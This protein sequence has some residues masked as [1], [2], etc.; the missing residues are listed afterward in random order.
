MNL[1][2]KSAKGEAF[3]EQAVIVSRFFKPPSKRSDYEM[4]G[5]EKLYDRNTLNMDMA[6]I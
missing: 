2:H 5:Q 4:L 6:A 3:K 1:T